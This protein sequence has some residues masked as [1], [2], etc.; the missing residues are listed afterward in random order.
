V[1]FA[2][3][4]P[5][6]LLG[7]VHRSAFK[8]SASVEVHATGAEPIPREAGGQNDMLRVN[9]TDSGSTGLKWTS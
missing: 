1:K 2:S 9:R 3:R 6:A 5:P 7:S 4:A 8:F